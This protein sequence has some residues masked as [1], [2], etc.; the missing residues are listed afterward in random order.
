MHHHHLEETVA[1]KENH[2]TP[3]H[4]PPLLAFLILLSVPMMEPEFKTN[5]LEEHGAFTGTVH[6]LDDF[7]KSV[8]GVRQGQ[9]NGQVI[10]DPSVPKEAFDAARIK[11]FLE[12]MA[13]PLFTHVSCICVYVVRKCPL[14]TSP[15]RSS[16]MRSNGW[17]PRRSAP[18]ASP[19]RG[20]ERSMPGWRNTSKTKWYAHLPFFLQPPVYFALH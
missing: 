5:V 4:N 7:L 17:N 2:S 3:P 6:K 1:C 10:P 14:M 20:S 18:V 11:G 15:T 16:S 12:E 8:L 9:K 13:D 19:H